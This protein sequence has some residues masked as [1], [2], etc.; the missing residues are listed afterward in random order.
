MSEDSTQESATNDKEYNFRAL[1]AKY[2]KRLAEERAEREKVMREANELREKMMRSAPQ[3][4]DDDDD[5][6]YVNHKRLSKTL[7]KTREEL[8][9]ESQREIQNA[10]HQALAEERQQQWLRS[11][12]DFYDVMKHADALAERA[13]ALAENILQMPEG[14][15][16]QKLVYHNIKTMGLDKPAA[17]EPSIEEK[18]QANRRSPYYQPSGMGATPYEGGGDFSKSGQK[19][20]YEKLKELK[21]R[22]RIG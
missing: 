13:P 2:E 8:K 17:K 19:Q 14:F 1:E 21:S 3:E 10:I 9:K 12:P 15:E 11:N 22:L 16:R 20:A 18:I 4:E 6:P 5:E 7:S